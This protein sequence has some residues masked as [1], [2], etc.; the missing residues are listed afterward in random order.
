[1][2]PRDKKK[3]LR[4]LVFC[5][6]FG[7]IFGF[8]EPDTLIHL[9]P[10]FI[11]DPDPHNPVENSNLSIGPPLLSRYRLMPAPSR[12]LKVCNPTCKKHSYIL[13]KMLLK[14]QTMLTFLRMNIL[15]LHNQV[16]H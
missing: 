8:L 14:D 9:N 5:L 10:I 3:K 7:A 1:M 13:L 12:L 2:M 15:F 6:V 11:A 16:K 4:I